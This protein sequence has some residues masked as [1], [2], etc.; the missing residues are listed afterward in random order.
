MSYSCKTALWWV[1]RGSFTISQ[2]DGSI[3]DTFLSMRSWTRG[4]VWVNG[5]N[6]GRFWTPSGP[7]ETLYVPKSFLLSGENE[8]VVL[9]LETAPH[10]SSVEFVATPSFSGSVNL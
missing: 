1:C 10:S 5:H 9:E 6:L 2:E 7:Q 4:M 8:L 3:R